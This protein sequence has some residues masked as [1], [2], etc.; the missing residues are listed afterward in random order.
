MLELI[1]EKLAHLDGI[2]LSS[3]VSEE[4][5]EFMKS[6]DPPALDVIEMGTHNGLSSALMS[7]YAGRVFTFDINLRNSE[8]IWQLLN[9]R[10]KIRAFVGSPEE[11]WLELNYLQDEYKLRKVPLD[12]N[13]AFI[14]DWHEY[15]AVKKSFETVQFC[16]RVLFHDYNCCSGVKI[17]C[18]EIRAKPIGDSQIFAY[19]EGK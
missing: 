3:A 17:F 16:G 12:F 18:D 9:V 1:K 6:L 5:E 4:F 8:Y 14:D 15:Y 19:W 10:E 13:F 7:A 2:L 11:I